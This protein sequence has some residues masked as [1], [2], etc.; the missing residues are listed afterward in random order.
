MGYLTIA[1]L[2]IAH[3]SERKE[4][5]RGLRL[6]HGEVVLGTGV[7]LGYLFL[8]LGGPLFFDD[9]AG[10]GGSGPLLLPLHFAALASAAQS[11]AHPDSGVPALA[12]ADP[13]LASAYVSAQ[14]A[15]ALP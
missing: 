8:I 14:V 9:P 7:C 2:A 15:P 1:L 13:S 11:L 5:Q 12:A 3:Y 4:C 10:P 6:S